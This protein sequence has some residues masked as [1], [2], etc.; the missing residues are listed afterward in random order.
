MVGFL[1]SVMSSTQGVNVHRTIQLK[2]T[3]D[4]H[5]YL[6]RHSNPRSSVRA[7]RAHAPVAVA[8]GS[9]VRLVSYN[10]IR[11]FPGITIIMKAVRLQWVE[12]EAKLGWTSSAKF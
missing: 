7:L 10:K 5:P 9:S 8:T 6:K 11:R 12:V 3:R 1:G 2:E 4:K